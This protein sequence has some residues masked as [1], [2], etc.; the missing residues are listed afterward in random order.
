MSEGGATG[1]HFARFWRKRSSPEIG[2]QHEKAA[3]ILR[4]AMGQLLSNPMLEAMKGMSL[5]KLLSMGGQALPT[6]LSDALDDAMR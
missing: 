5:R 3:A 4:N 6:E 2:R 1:R